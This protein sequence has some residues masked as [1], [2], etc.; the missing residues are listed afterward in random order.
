M[1]FL[2]FFVVCRFIVM[3]W[4]CLLFIGLIISELCLVRNVVFFF[5]LLVRCC[6]GWCRLVCCRVWWVR[7]LFW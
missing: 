2:I 1:V 4:F 7:I 6:C 3:F 5:V